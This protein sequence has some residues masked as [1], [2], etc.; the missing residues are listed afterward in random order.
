MSDGNQSQ[1]VFELGGAIEQLDLGYQKLESIQQEL[2]EQMARLKARWHGEASMAF[3]SALRVY[4]E[5]F[6]LTQNELKDIRARLDVSTTDYA[7][8]EK[9]V[10]AEAG[11][12]RGEINF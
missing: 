2:Q 4:N 6:D 12:L 1:N 7:T 3:D 5:K 11:G 8:T 10:A 9:N